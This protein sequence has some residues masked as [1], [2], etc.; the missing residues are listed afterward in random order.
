M[1][2]SEGTA[3]LVTDKQWERDRD[4][5]LAREPPLLSLQGAQVP[6][7]V[8]KGCQDA[9][10]GNPASSWGEGTE[11]LIGFPLWRGGAL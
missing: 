7:E 1:G 4:D 10:L 5:S 3:R 9:E 8:Q 2:T 6:S 11:S